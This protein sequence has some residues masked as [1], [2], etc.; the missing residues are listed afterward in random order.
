[1]DIREAERRG[2]LERFDPTTDYL[3]HVAQFVDL[4]A[5]RNAGLNIVV[6]SM[7]GAG[8]GYFDT[9][10]SGGSTRIVELHGEVNPAFPGMNQPEPITANLEHADRRDGRRHRRHRAGDRRR[11]RPARSR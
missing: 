4:E 2:L 11:R 1:M 3:N 9:L 8:A 10:I 7:Y 6:D 5:I